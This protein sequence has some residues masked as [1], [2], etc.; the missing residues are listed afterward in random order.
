MS[1]RAARTN[2]GKASKLKALQ[3]LEK[4]KSEGGRG[5]QY[6]VCHST[7]KKRREIKIVK[8]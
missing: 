5:Q 4:A 3:D 1:R 8:K 7:L 2:V 6:E